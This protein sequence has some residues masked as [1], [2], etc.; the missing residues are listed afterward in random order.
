ME[1]EDKTNDEIPENLKRLVRIMLRAFYSFEHC[2]SKYCYI[3]KK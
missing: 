1:V 2:L 3:F